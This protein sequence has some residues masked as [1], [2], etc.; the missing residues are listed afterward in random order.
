MNSNDN[1]KTPH[2]RIKVF[3]NFKFLYKYP[4]FKF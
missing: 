3:R 1:V 4:L 2:F